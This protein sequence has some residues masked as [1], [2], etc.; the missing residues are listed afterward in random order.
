VIDLRDAWVDDPFALFPTSLHRWL[1]ILLERWVASG[2]CR[3]VSINNLILDGL[4]ERYGLSESRLA[5]VDQGFDPEDF[6]QSVEPNEKFTI[7]YTGSL[8]RTRR[9]DDLFNAVAEL[10]G[11][12]TMERSQLEI[13]IV[14]FCPGEFK[15]SAARLGIEDVVQ[16]RGYLPHR[17]SVSHLLRAS[18]LWLY[19]AESEGDTILTG[20]LF[21]YLGSGK[22]IIASVPQGG[23]AASLVRDTGAG[24]V[25]R[26]GDV[27]GLREAIGAHYRKWLAGDSSEQASPKAGRF[28]RRRLTGR[29][30][31]ILSEVSQAP[32]R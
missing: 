31:T 9:P 25:I 8:V 7:C 32:G 15:E 26:P 16:F 6:E 2:A 13:D 20:K 17:E 4:R 24:T 5:V 27:A 1:N 14:G 22:P 10:L 3:V 19:V 11:S 21:E 12:G 30:A 29:L 18:L 23:E 28:D